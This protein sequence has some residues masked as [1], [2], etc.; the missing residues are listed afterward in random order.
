MLKKFSNDAHG[1][2]EKLERRF[3]SHETMNATNIIYPEFGFNQKLNTYSLR[4]L[5]FWSSIIVMGGTMVPTKLLSLPCLMRLKLMN[6]HFFQY[7]YDAWGCN[8]NYNPCSKMWVLLTNNQIIFH[9]LY[10]WLKF[11]KLFMIMVLGSVE[12]ER[13][14]KRIWNNC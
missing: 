12:D 9:K 7:D 5:V 11:I 14:C 3:L 1:L 4:N 2:I 10:E 6:K 13:C 8:I